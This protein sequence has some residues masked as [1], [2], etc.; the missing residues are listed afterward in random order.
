MKSAISRTCGV[1]LGLI[2]LKHLTGSFCSWIG[3]IEPKLGTG[4]KW[5]DVDG[6]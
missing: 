3:K 5:G 6:A 1:R 2:S 4:L